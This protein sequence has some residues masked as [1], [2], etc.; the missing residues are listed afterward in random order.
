MSQRNIQKKQGWCEQQQRKGVGQKQN[1]ANT[2][3]ANKRVAALDA[4]KAHALTGGSSSETPALRASASMSAMKSGVRPS[5]LVCV[6]WA[7]APSSSSSATTSNANQA[8]QTIIADVAIMRSQR[9]RRV[10]VCVFSQFFFQFWVELSQP[11]K[12]KSLTFGKIPL[13]MHYLKTWLSCYRSY[14]C[15]WCCCLFVYCCN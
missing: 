8:E 6:C 7:R 4:S 14:R 10:C 9:T 15:C 13:F 1:S 2:T 12:K 11:N 3:R 5:S